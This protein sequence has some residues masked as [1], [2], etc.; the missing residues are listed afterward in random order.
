MTDIQRHVPAVVKALSARLQALADHGV[1]ELT[2]EHRDS[3]ASAVRA[4]LPGSYGVGAGTVV[5]V[6]G[7]ESQP[8]DLV[9]YDRTLAR[10]T[11]YDEHDRY[12]V[13]HVLAAFYLRLY[14][15]EASLHAMLDAIAG[16][17][18]LTLRSGASGAADVRAAAAKRR[19][20]R[21]PLAIALFWRWGSG[22][23]DEDPS[24]EDLALLL[25]CAVA[26]RSE[27]CWPDEVRALGRDLVYRRPET[28]DGRFSPD[29]TGLTRLP[30]LVRPRSCYVCKADFYRRHF[31]Y[32]SLCPRCGDLNYARRVATADLGGRVALVTGARTGIG[33]AVALKLLRAGAV[34]VATTR[35]PHDAARRFAREQDCADWAARL[36]ICGLDL[37]YVPGVEAFADRLGAA[38]ARLDILV[39]NAAQTVR[40]PP[41]FYT[42]LLPFESRPRGEL[43]SLARALLAPEEWP[44]I[45]YPMDRP[46]ASPWRPRELDPP[47]RDPRGELLQQDGDGQPALAGALIGGNSWTARLENLSAVEMLEVQ[48][49]NNVAPALLLGR[50]K[51]LLARAA[52]PGA[53]VVNVA[54]AEGQFAQSKRGAHPHTNMAK[55]A[56]NM[57][58]HTVAAE[59]ARDH[60]FVTSVDPGWVSYQASERAGQ[61][62]QEGQEEQSSQPQLPLDLVDA[63]ARVCDP[64]FTGLTTGQSRYGVLLKDYAEAAW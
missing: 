16:V 5:G 50:L 1:T 14:H 61:A 4:L 23:S 44:A 22:S 2:A 36:R 15:D 55:A 28:G 30:E 54:A 59:Y 35:F 45:G 33:H 8:V 40:R 26:E 21:Y 42:D 64:I 24:A 11:V 49:V 62:G 58:T 19:R 46:S 10:E 37:R 43:P 6:D 48:I 34:V 31:F 9:I 56:L 12:R 52:A 32:E 18:A 13:G 63:A 57:L 39:N 20:G 53:H 7:G 60:I 17:K 25:H 47:A 29:D 3:L 38:Y 51:W 41:S 27:A